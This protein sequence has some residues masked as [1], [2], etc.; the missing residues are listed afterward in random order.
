[1]EQKMGKFLIGQQKNSEQISYSSVD[2][3]NEGPVPVNQRF[4][5]DPSNSVN[6]NL[7]PADVNITAGARPVL[8]YSIQTGEE[9]ALEFMWERVNPRQQYIPNSSVEASSETTPMDLPAVRGPSHAGSGRGPDASLFPTV[10]RAN[11]QDPVGT[12]SPI[13][14]K[15]SGKPLQSVA[16]ISSKHASGNRFHSRSSLGS[17]DGSTRILK[18]LCSFGGKV[19]PRPSDRKLRYVGGETR[20][21]RISK[22]ISWEELKQKTLSLCNEPHTVKY[23]LPGE[24][25]DALVSVSSDE[26]L[27]NMM[28]ECSVLDDGGSQKLRV[29]LISNS[30]LD[31][32]QLGLENV[33]GDS[34]IQYF[35]AVNGMDL[36]SRRNSIVLGS[37]LGNNLDEL[38]TLNAE[39]QTGQNSLAAGGTAH[40][41]I[42]SPSPNQSSQMELPSSSHAFEA[43]SRGYQIQTINHEQP[44]WHSSRAFDEKIIVSP[45]VRYQYDY[46]SH[47][48]D[49]AP[50][51]EN[52]VSNLIHGHMAP[53]EA[54][55]VGQ[56]YGSLNAKV[57]EVSGLEVKLNNETVVPRNIESDHSPGT[58][59]LQMETQMNKESSIRE[60]NDSTKVQ[61]LENVSSHPYNVP[62]LS[63]IK[64][65]ETS[66]TSAATDKGTLVI[67][68]K[69][70]EKNQD[71]TRNS[72]SLNTVQDE[73]MS[74][75][76]VDEHSYTSGVPFMPAHSD[77]EAYSENISYEPDIL[78]HRLFRSER[79]PREQAGLNRLSKSNDSF[80]PQLLMTHSRSDVSQQ[81]TESVD[82]MTDWNVS[83][84]LE[85]VHAFGKSAGMNPPATEEKPK[86]S[87][88]L[89]EDADEISSMN[90]SFRDKNESNHESELNAAVAF[91]VTPGSSFPM[92]S[93]GTSQ[94]PQVESAVTLTEIR[95]KMNE[96]VNEGKLHL[97]GSGEIPFAAASQSKPRFVAGPQEHGDIQ[98][99]INDR[100]PNDFLS[101]IFSKARIMESSPGFTPYHGDASGLS[102]NL[103]N[104]EPKHWSYFQKLAQG[105]SRKDVSLMDQDHLTFSSAQA[106]AGEDASV[107]YGYPPFEAGAIEADHVNSSSNLGADTQRQLSGLVGP[108]T[109][110]LHSDYDISQTTGIQSLQFSRPINSTTAGSDYED[111][112]KAAQPTGFPLIDF[113]LGEFDPSSLQIIKNRDLEEL[114]E[115]GSGTY[116]T[117]YHGKWRGTDVAIKRIKKSCFM[118]RSSE[119]EKLTAEFWHE[120]EILSKLHHPNVVAFYGVVQDGPGGTLA[121]V[122]EYMVNGSLR[123]ALISKERHLDRRKRIIIAM[124]AAFGMEYL[125]SRNIVHFD[126][127]CDN[128]LVN[129]KDTSRPICKVGDFGL[130]K[131]KRNTLVTGGVRGTLPWMAPELLNGSSSKVSEKVDVFSFGIVLWEILTG[132]EPYANMH[133]GAIIGGIVNNTLRP[134]VP[135]FCDAEW[136]LLMEQCWAPDPLA[137]PCFTEIATRLRTMSLT[138]PQVFTPQNQLS[139]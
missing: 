67:P 59:V 60:T 27:Q 75:F 122:T 29:F 130:S 89:T 16:R 38:L 40:P 49:H 70:S 105:D 53:Q 85:K 36:G 28:E 104:H 64:S 96:I 95:N 125:H 17:F 103:T 47:P 50:L 113:S 46:A 11:V 100:F 19:L 32:S 7:R 82:K 86:E 74:K 39:R 114:R 55:T 51:A 35:V 30:D 94:Y 137:R 10:E 18:L 21:L 12:S 44:E 63:D 132:E 6:M 81:I 84:N 102:V 99:D 87:R 133:Y 91:T 136:R 15:F 4:N 129:L 77:S 90:S 135:S 116:G 25:L 134:P 61:S 33:E 118:G 73:K 139:K 54:P 88:N 109:M 34:D 37:H 9:F 121:T 42:V 138:K 31:D 106:T 22:D 13:E 58:D 8:N 76:D 66:V 71:D 124:D 23:Q 3:R 62:S 48:S 97:V 128:L 1:M 92:A 117:V 20:I 98:I 119:Q 26:D 123:H 2:K 68:A 127:K 120:A 107:D 101:D 69:V 57:P 110:N 41:E 112:R 43:N 111:G 14:E 78:P 45:S 83:A 126:L 24:D 52:L 72:V 5:Q 65:E 79:I 93:Q 56:P 115:L 80:G 131:I 108:D